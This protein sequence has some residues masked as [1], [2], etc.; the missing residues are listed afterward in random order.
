MDG[1]LFSCLDAFLPASRTSCLGVCG[2]WPGQKE[3]SLRGPPALRR[4]ATLFL[5]CH[6]I[7]SSVGMEVTGHHIRSL[8]CLI[9]GGL[10]SHCFPASASEHG[11]D[12]GRPLPAT[13][14]RRVLGAYGSQVPSMPRLLLH[15]IVN[16]C[17]GRQQA[18]AACVWACASAQHHGQNDV[19]CVLRAGCCLN[20]SGQHQ[21]I[22]NHP[23]PQGGSPA[24]HPAW[25]LLA[26][27]A[28]CAYH[29]HGHVTAV[30]HLIA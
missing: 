8:P 26:A 12:R 28:A 11:S 19:L 22:S 14:D 9:W 5:G 13:A 2:W 18:F 7:A 25:L 29:F 30:T 16:L 6:R 1:A 27:V 20:W 21:C 15:A 3:S 17:P 10:P 4:P 23:H 24:N